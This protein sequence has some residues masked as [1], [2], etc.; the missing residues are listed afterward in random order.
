MHAGSDDFGEVAFAHLCS[1][2]ASV[3]CA[4]PL[5]PCV[6]A[7]L[8]WDGCRRRWLCSAAMGAETGGHCRIFCDL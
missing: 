7:V 5:R 3:S 6:C 4:Q 1:D 2:A 8:S